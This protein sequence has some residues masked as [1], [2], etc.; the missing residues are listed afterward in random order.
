MEIM[1]HANLRKLDLS[2]LLLFEALMEERSVTRAGNRLLLTQAGVSHALTRL[3]ST[4]KDELFIREKGQMRPTARA[5]AL[6]AP[7]KEALNMLEAALNPTDFNPAKSKQTFRLI[8][9]DYFAT[10]VLPSI[11]LR[12]ER[13]APHVDLR[14]LSNSLGDVG[15][16][17]CSNDV[18]FAVG[19][20]NRMTSLIRSECTAATLFED[21]YVCVLRKGH[22][23]AQRR[24]TK[25]RYLDS[26][27]ILFSP[28]GS[29]DYGVE[30]Y[31][32]PMGIKRHIGVIL[33][34]Y[35]AAPLILQN[36]DMIMTAPKRLAQFYVKHY[37]VRIAPLPLKISPISIQLVWNSQFDNHAAYRWFRFLIA[38]VCRSVSRSR[39]G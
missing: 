8:G 39:K 38:N 19:F 14:I 6:A 7:L 26:K 27:H 32:R 3:R 17:L 23:F 35:L 24:L 2:L 21:E 37:S 31:L 16:M 9:T 34:H 4:L 28:T 13:E 29:A 10:V 30:T 22:E 5:M 12:L 33:S 18:D 15:A 25:A 20:K 11:I 1:R 36:S